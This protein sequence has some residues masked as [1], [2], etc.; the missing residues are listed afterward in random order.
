MVTCVKPRPV[1]IGKGLFKL[2]LKTKTVTAA[3][4]K[5]PG[6]GVAAVETKCPPGSAP[7]GGGSDQKSIQLPSPKS[8]ARAALDTSPTMVVV[9]ARIAPVRGGFLFEYFNPTADERAV[10]PSIRCAPRT[11]KA[12]RKRKRR[13]VNVEVVRRIFA[14]T[15]P[16]RTTSTFV[17]DCGRG[18]FPIFAGHMWSSRADLFLWANSIDRRTGARWM[19]QNG[20]ATPQPM[21]LPA[22]CLTGSATR[23]FDR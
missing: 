13:K 3:P 10:Q 19:I 15:V 7:V 21:D 22:L 4:L 1:L 5:V 2:K 9:E 23:Q 17:H 14:A 18:R 12:R 8:R 11:Q 16:A 20:T 6:Q